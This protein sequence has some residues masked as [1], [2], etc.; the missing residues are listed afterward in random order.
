[1]ISCIIISFDLLPAIVNI[2]QMIC[3][4]LSKIKNTYIYQ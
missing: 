1:M 2:I 3:V 4:G